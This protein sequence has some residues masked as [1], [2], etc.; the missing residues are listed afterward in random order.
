MFYIITLFIGMGIG[1]RMRKDNC[2]NCKE[3]KKCN[4][5]IYN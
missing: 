1:L 5:C 2:D 3:I 4:G